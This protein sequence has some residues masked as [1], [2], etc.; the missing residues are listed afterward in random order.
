MQDTNTA[1]GNWLDS[2]G[3]G[4]EMIDSSTASARYVDDLEKGKAEG[5]TPV[6]VVDDGT[7]DSRLLFMFNEY[8]VE[9]L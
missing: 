5:Y 3:I 2:H 8:D 9:A 6:I 4:S 7:E 1:L